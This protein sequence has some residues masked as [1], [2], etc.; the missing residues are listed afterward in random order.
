MTIVNVNDTELFYIKHGSGTPFLVMHGGLGFDHT[1]FRPELDPLG[2]QLQL[3]YFD[4]RGHGR[5]GRPPVSTITFD[6]LA[7]DTEELRKVLGFGKIGVI[8]HS[9]GG[10]VALKYA[11][12]FPQ[13]L[14]HLILLNTFPAFDRKYVK[15]SL[16]EI[17]AKNPSPEVMKAFNAPNSTTLEDLKQNLRIINYLYVFNFNSEIKKRFDKMIDEMNFNLEIS[18]INGL[19]MSKFNVLED[20]SKITAPTLIIG[21]KGDAIVPVSQAKRLYENIRNSEIY[22]FEKSGHY[23]FLE[24]PELFINII[25]KWFNKMK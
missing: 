5:S 6:Q 13:N 15:D 1:Y 16:T 20:L 18:A 8:G 21:G 11:I 12:N 19:L 24:E 22:L 3:I 10:L 14:S 25:L 7:D 9:A 23:P 2:G 17:Q 4:Y